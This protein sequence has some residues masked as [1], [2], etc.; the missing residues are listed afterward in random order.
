MPAPFGNQ[1]A[2]G[3][4]G[5]GRPSLA[6]ER[7]NAQILWDI[8]EGKYTQE[9]LT[10]IITEKKYGVKHIFASKC[11]MGNEKLMAKLVDKLYANKQ[12]IE[13]VGD[14]EEAEIQRAK[15]NKLLKDVETIVATNTSVDNEVEPASC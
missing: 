6:Q 11:M 8:W 13:Q 5:G 7:E 3:N 15:L 2:V 9:E 14:A 12:K 4:P 1:N 10:K